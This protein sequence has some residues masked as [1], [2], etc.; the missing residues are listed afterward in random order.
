MKPTI[1]ALVLLLYPIFLF[2]QE[3]F[4]TKNIFIITIDGFRWQELYQGADPTLIFDK[5]FVSDTSLMRQLFWDEK[6]SARRSKLLPF[7][8]SV[9]AEKGQLYGNR[10]LG[11]RVNVKNIY[12]IS[13]PGYNE[14]LTGYT[15]PRIMLNVPHNNRNTTVL[16]YLNQQK[17]FEG[18][19]VAFSSWNMFPYILNAE[20]SRLAIN[21]GYELIAHSPDDSTFHFID[22]V[23]EN[24]VHKSSTRYDW[25][26]F[27]NAREYIEQ[28]HPRVVFLGFGETDHYAHQARYDMYLQRANA[29]DKMI[30]ELWYF[31]QSD[32][33]YKDKTTFI[34]TT[35]HGRGKNADTWYTHLFFVG[36]SGQTWLAMLGPDVAPLGEIKN[37]EQIYQKQ[38]AST[39]ALILGQQFTVSHPVAGPIS[40]PQNHEFENAVNQQIASK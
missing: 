9:I 25:L 10:T 34:I 16:E 31:V 13:Y 22:Q 38:V 3:N 2:S 4:K 21:S 37:K 6:A 20:R 36:G 39:V 18:K 29:I 8:W 40:L 27:L 28:N 24:V 33:F 30:S 14:I 12:K 35:D 15:D 11:N 32:P 5:K 19:V 26:T 17:D 1:A 23:Q 7:F